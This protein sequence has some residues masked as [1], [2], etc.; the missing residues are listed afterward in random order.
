MLFVMFFNAYLPL[1][2]H[3]QRPKTLLHNDNG[4]YIYILVFLNESFS[5]FTFSQFYLQVAVASMRY[6][7]L[8][9]IVVFVSLAT[10]GTDA[11]AIQMIVR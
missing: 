7:S 9:A 3:K 11:R 6:P 2:S 10:Q 1:I 4:I 8:A 5:M